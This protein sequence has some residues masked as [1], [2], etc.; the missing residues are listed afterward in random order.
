MDSMDSSVN[1]LGDLIQSISYEQWLDKYS[2]IDDF[3]QSI[4]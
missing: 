2:V 3:Q 1:T 4:V